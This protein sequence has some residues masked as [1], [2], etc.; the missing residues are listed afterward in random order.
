MMQQYLRI[1]AQHP[2]ML[3]LYR[4]GD[5]YELFYED[6]E[7]AARLLDI[8]LTQRGA[9]AGDP[10]KMAG[11]PYHAIEQY[12]ARLVKLGESAAICEQIGDPS[13]SKG[14]VERQVMRI[15]TPGTL[16]DAALLE[17]KRDN[18]L[19]AISPG[20]S[21]LGVAWIS[22]ASGDFRV[23]ET[24]AANLPSEL[25]RLGPAEV[26]LP[27]GSEH[28]L[29]DGFNVPAKRLPAWNF[30]RDSAIRALTKQFGT[31]DLS[32]FGGEGLDA[33]LGAAGA[34]L[35]YCRT[36]QGGD[37]AHVRALHVERDSAYLRL[38]AVSRRNLEISET[39]RGARRLQLRCWTAAPRVVGLL[40]AHCHRCAQGD[41]GTPD[42][43]ET[44]PALAVPGCSA[45]RPAS[46][47]PPT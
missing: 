16:T 17:D 2:D 1:K 3:L 7:K 40:K 33:A 18:L 21:L 8:T 22:L 28:L 45:L 23:L 15:I 34:L 14:P 32:G 13:T 27:D 5:F 25:E 12:L 44:P 31:Q 41:P 36:T 30:D 9:S 11:V 39:L 24:L 10:I 29:P 43:V 35:E 46:S 37:L 47:A 20:K 42:A 19:L 4:M 38:D 6:A 26:L